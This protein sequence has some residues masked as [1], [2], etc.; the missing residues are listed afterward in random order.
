MLEID[1]RSLRHV[2]DAGYKLPMNGIVVADRADDFMIT[3]MHVVLAIRSLLAPSSETQHPR[4]LNRTSP[5]GNK[6]F[7]FSDQSCREMLPKFLQIFY[8]HR[9]IRH[10][11]PAISF[12][13]AAFPPATLTFPY[14]PW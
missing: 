5:F 8:G 7:K 2:M 1:T 11:P 4:N 14:A 10:V 13:F 6:S 3:Q 9:R 12:W